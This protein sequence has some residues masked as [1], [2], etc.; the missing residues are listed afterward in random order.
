MPF[1]SGPRSVPPA[2]ISYFSPYL[3]IPR[4]SSCDHLERALEQ[5][6]ALES[7][8]ANAVDRLTPLT[9]REREVATLVCRGL[10]NRGIADE[11]GIAALHVEHIRGKLGFHSRAQIAA[12][13]TQGAPLVAH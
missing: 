2:P 13:I 9:A 12:W 1:Q 5:A 4:S 11:L 8:R 3:G 6:R 7:K 10:T